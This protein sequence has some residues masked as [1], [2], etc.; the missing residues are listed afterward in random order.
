[1]PAGGETVTVLWLWL[2]PGRIGRGSGGR[3]AL[4][5]PWITHPRHADAGEVRVPGMV[6]VAKHH[7]DGSCWRGSGD[8]RPK[9][10]PVA[11]LRRPSPARAGR[12]RPEQA[13]DPR[14]RVAEVQG[15][16][17]KAG[18]SVKAGQTGTLTEGTERVPLTSLSPPGRGPAE[19]AGRALQAGVSAEGDAQRAVLLQATQA[20]RD[21]PPPHHETS[22]WVCEI[23]GLTKEKETVPQRGCRTQPAH[24]GW[25]SHL[26]RAWNTDLLGGLR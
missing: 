10:S 4:S 9:Q 23:P 11:S 13:Q 16:K 14:G 26:S 24:A 18:R 15:L 25:A 1:M 17:H 2:S 19:R 7:G 3:G 20:P 22:A 12:R 8:E 6:A 5:M 21:L